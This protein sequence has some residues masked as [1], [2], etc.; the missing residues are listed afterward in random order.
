MVYVCSLGTKIPV[1]P[2]DLV[3][4]SERHRNGVIVRVSGD[5]VD[6][7]LHYVDGDG[8]HYIG[9]LT[10]SRRRKDRIAH[11]DVD[12]EIIKHKDLVENY[13]RAAMLIEREKTAA[14]IECLE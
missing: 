4:L 3:P 5:K 12:G 13:G 9:I 14:A 6:F 11:I 8:V 2:V 1:I 10:R 7:M